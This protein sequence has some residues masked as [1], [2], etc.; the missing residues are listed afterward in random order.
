MWFAV[1]KNF[2][3]NSVSLAHHLITRSHTHNNNTLYTRIN[4]INI[5]LFLFISKIGGKSEH[6]P[7]KIASINDSIKTS[8]PT[9]QQKSRSDQSQIVIQASANNIKIIM[10]IIIIVVVDII[11]MIMIMIYIILSLYCLYYIYLAKNW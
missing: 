11:I 9:E 8:N 4:N 1:N 3:T 10:I 5:E 6:V 2:Q 7:R